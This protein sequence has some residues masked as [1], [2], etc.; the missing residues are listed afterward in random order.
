MCVFCVYCTLRVFSS[1]CVNVCVFC[2]YNSCVFP[3]VLVLVLV[4]VSFSV[5]VCIHECAVT[6]LVNANRQH[7]PVG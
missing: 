4:C 3:S 1:V 5:C 6:P 2:V 7:A